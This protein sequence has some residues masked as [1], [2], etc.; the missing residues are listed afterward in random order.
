M[1][2]VDIYYYFGFY[3]HCFAYFP[4]FNQRKNVILVQDKLKEKGL[5]VSEDQA[6]AV[7]REYEDKLWGVH[8][9]LGYGLAFLLLSRVI[10]ELT[11]PGEEK[12]RSRIRNALGLSRKKEGDWKEYRYYLIV[13]YCYLLFYILL[14]CI[15]I[16]GLG[17][18]FGSE[19][20][21]SRELH[22][23]IK[24]IHSLGQY[25]IY[26]FVIIHLCGVI[27]SDNTKNKGLVSG[28]INGNK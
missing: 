26:A 11:L 24:E 14:F 13:K 5:I 10:I 19:L 6:F 1:A 25:L 12:I 27:I 9:L 4:L 7:T 18:A 3:S 17:L 20:G 23:T 8:K 2:L 28:M 16:T 22:G 21:F 15:A